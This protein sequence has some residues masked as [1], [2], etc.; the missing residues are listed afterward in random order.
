MDLTRE[1]YPSTSGFSAIR[2]EFIVFYDRD[3]RQRLNASFGI[4]LDDSESLG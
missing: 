2:R 3:L 1:V 4:R